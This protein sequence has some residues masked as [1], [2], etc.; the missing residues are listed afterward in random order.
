M[1]FMDGVVRNTEFF[2]TAE[3]AE[4]LKMNVQVL[5]RKVQAGE[6]YAYKI[7]K[8]WRIPEQ[9]VHEWLQRNLNRGQNKPHTTIVDTLADASA[10]AAQ[11]TA[12][13]GAGR[14]KFLLEYILA[15]FEPNR[16]Y[17]EDEVNRIILR[18]H[19]NHVAVRN[20][21]IAE[22]MMDEIDG[23]YRRRNGYTLARRSA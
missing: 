11:V 9:S 22:Q 23:R 18:H 12:A 3:L 13:E 15:Q 10:S 16:L 21:F 2:T 20:E 17:S 7:G 1:S 5:T 19:E 4:K 6:L 14:R 8:E